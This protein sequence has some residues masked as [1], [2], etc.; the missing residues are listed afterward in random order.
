LVPASD[1]EIAN[2]VTALREKFDV[3]YVAL[4]HCTGEQAFAAFRRA[5]GDHYLYAGLGTTLSV[6]GDLKR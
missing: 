1:Q 6:G 2:S 4:G 3:D 5:F